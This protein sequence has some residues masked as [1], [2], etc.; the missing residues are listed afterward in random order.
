M[1]PSLGDYLP[2]DLGVCGACWSVVMF[3]H[4]DAHERWHKE[5]DEPVGGW[6]QVKEY[7]T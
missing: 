7:Q 4:R 6:V 2:I 3:R 5:R 1:S